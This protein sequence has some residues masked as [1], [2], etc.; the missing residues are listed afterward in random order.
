MASGN[1]LPTVM[2]DLSLL[3]CRAR[4]VWLIMEQ[5]VMAALDVKELALALTYIKEI[6]G[7]FPKSQRCI[8]LSVRGACLP[9]FALLLCTAVQCVEARP[10]QPESPVALPECCCRKLSWH[11][12][13]HQCGWHAGEG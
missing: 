13:A 1:G 5:V 12:Q 6:K 8:R 3:L 9:L 7:K 2:I 4:A 11:Q 10:A